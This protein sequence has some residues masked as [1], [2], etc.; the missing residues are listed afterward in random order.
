[1]TRETGFAQERPRT[2]AATSRCRTGTDLIM[3]CNCSEGLA[4]ETPQ[5]FEAAA[6][7]CP[8]GPLNGQRWEIRNVKAL[9][10]SRGFYFSM[11]GWLIGVLVHRCRSSLVSPLVC[12]CDRHLFAT[13]ALSPYL[14]P[15]LCSY[16]S[17]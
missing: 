2:E 1:M 16:M 11:T 9:C 14:S 6:W 7:P 8:A 3:T 10:V 13:A 15:H 5:S 12:L 4:K 17:H